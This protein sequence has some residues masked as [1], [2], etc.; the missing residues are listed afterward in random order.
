MSRRIPLIAVASQTA[1]VVLSGQNCQLRLRT[2]GGALY[3][4]LSVDNDP[5]IV[6][7]VCRN[8]TR[9]LLAQDYTGFQGDF[10]FVDTQGDTQPEYTGLADRYALLYLTEAEISG[11]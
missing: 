10:V 1:S 3:F 6:N 7:H 8:K 5:V 4:S 9:M 11:S 2:M